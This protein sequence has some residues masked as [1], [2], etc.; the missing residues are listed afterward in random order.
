MK[1]HSQEFRVNP[2]ASVALG[3]WPTSVKPVFKSTKQYHK[4]LGQHVE[5]LSALQASIT[6]PAA[7]PCC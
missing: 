4:L 3:R 5:A 6:H 2:G 1:I 7:M